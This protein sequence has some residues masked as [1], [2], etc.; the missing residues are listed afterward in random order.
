MR[1]LVKVNRFIL[2]YSGEDRVLEETVTRI[3]FSGSSDLAALAC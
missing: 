1:V 2:D 3:P